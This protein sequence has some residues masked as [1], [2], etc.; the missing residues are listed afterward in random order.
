MMR[1]WI[2]RP[3]ICGAMALVAAIAAVATAQDVPFVGVVEQDNVE[4]R[5]GAGRAYYLVGTLRKGQKVQVD[6]IIFGWPQIVAPD[7]TYSFVSKAFIDAKGDGKSGIVNTDR[8]AVKAAA[9]T[10]SN[11]SY[12]QQ[13]YLMKG[14]TVEIVGEEFGVYKIRPPVGAFVYVAP[15]TVRRATAAEI[16]PTAVTPPT[17][18]TPPGTGHTPPQP[19]QSIEDMIRQTPP[20]PP[21]PPE[22]TPGETTQP[23]PDPVEAVTPPTPPTPP[24]T[25]GTSTGAAKGFEIEPV[26]DRV[27]QIDA[28]MKGAIDLPLEQQPT[29]ELLADYQAAQLDPQLPP[30]DRE[31]V[32]FRI[33]TLKRNKALAEGLRQLTDAKAQA[34]AA[35]AAE[36]EPQE[37][38]GPVTYAAVGQLLASSV[39]DGV[40]LPRMYRIVAPGGG[41]TI[42]YIQ[43]GQVRNATATLGKIVGVAGPMRFDPALKANVID[44]KRVDV[45]EKTSEPSTPAATPSAADESDA[46]LAVPEP[47]A[48]QPAATPAPVEPAL[49]EALDV[50]K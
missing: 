42:A 16:E 28:R 46:A 2:R 7:G 23:E 38:T 35:K 21:T 47:E 40:T 26:S 11:D 41:R 49:D 8:T 33:A 15:G 34:Q 24:T 19:G 48:A 50:G 6:K 5:A 1:T 32:K 27:K 29:D 20:T 18:P 37:M 43:P 3:V 22:P 25:T 17:P 13:V 9:I 14:D 4:V 10:G 31:I 30:L 45:L 39:Y 44:A 36:R 12:R